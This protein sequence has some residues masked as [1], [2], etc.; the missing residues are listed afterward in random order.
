[1]MKK[2]MPP[3]FSQALRG[4]K[5]IKNASEI[6]DVLRQVKV[7]IPLLDMIQASTHICKVFEGL[8]HCEKRT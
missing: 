3:P 7:N 5:P 6:L 2:H 4:K 1:M 8:V